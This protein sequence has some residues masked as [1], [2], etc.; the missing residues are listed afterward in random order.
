MRVR[1]VGRR[2]SEKRARL[3]GVPGSCPAARDTCREKCYRPRRGRLV[4][5]FVEIGSCFRSAAPRARSAGCAPESARA[6][7]IQRYQAT[8]GRAFLHGVRRR[9]CGDRDSIEMASSRPPP[10]QNL[11]I[12][13]AGPV[14]VVVQNR[15]TPTDQEWDRLL[16]LFVDHRTELPKLKLMV[17]TAGGGPSAPQRK[18]LEAA[19]GGTPMRVAVVS[20]NMKVRFVASTIALFHKDHRSFLTSEMDEACDHLQLTPFER[21]EAQSVVRQIAS[22]LQQ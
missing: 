13:R 19:L 10:R 2:G 17:L 3:R 15:E 18:R 20:D 21:R 22:L 6:D 16:A 14:I 8:P 12:R 4:H 9:L 7:G 11:L 1:R 5:G